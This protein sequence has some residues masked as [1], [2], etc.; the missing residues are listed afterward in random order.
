MRFLPLFMM[1]F[2]VA[3]TPTQQEYK[4]GGKD[5]VRMDAGMLLMSDSVILPYRSWLPESRKYKKNP[6][7]IIVGLHGFNDYSNSFD[8]V[9]TYFSKNNMAVFAYDQR[10]F[11]KTQP[12]GIWGNEANFINDLRHFIL[13]LSVIYPRSPVYILG[14]SMGGAVA[15]ASTADPAFPPVNGVILVA[16]AVWGSETM[17]PIFR[18]TLWLAAHTFP[19]RELTGSDLK[20]IASNNYPMLWKM[21]RDPLVQKKS[22]VDA[23]YGMVQLMDSAYEKI[24]DIKTPVLLMYGAKDQV[25]P[26]F[27]VM[28]ALTRF[29]VPVTYAYYPQ[30]YHMLL[31]DLQGEEVMAD[32]LHWMKRPTQPLPSGFSKVILPNAESRREALSKR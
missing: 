28:N 1:A 26:S 19:F 30:G 12:L 3:C 7:A 25:I 14:E 11:G 32:M 2:L 5:K 16:P 6:R 29:H 17:N 24:P 9:G 21:S 20:I 23:V 31:R 22:R 10:G 15:I 18:G 13:Q 27:A 4:A 8:G